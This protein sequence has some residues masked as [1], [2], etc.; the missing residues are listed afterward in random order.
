MGEFIEGT[1]FDDALVGGEGDDTL[2]G[3]QGY[4]TLEGLGGND[5]LWGGDDDDVLLGG[6]GADTLDSSLGEDLSE[7][8]AGDDYLIAGFGR[9]TLTGGEGNDLFWVLSTQEG[10]RYGVVTEIVT[11]TDLEAGEAVSVG[12]T[13]RTSRTPEGFPVLVF[14]GTDDFSSQGGEVR[15]EVSDGV[16]VLEADWDGDGAANVRVDFLGEFDLRQR[17]PAAGSVL[18]E[19][20]QAYRIEE[21][22]GVRAGGTGGGDAIEGTDGNDTLIGAAGDDELTGGEG[23][24]LIAGGFG[25]DTL[26]GGAGQDYLIAG[27]GRDVVRGGEDRDTLA[28]D[29]LDVL[30]A[31][32][33]TVTDVAVNLDAEALLT[34]EDVEALIISRRQAGGHEDRLDASAATI[35]VGLY[36]GEGNDTLIGGSGADTIEGDGGVDVM[37]GG[38]GADVFDFDDLFEIGMLDDALEPVADVIVDFEPAD[39]LDL[40]GLNG[41]GSIQFIGAGAFTAESQLRYFHE[42]GRTIVE[43]NEFGSL[44][45]IVLGSGEFDL[46]ETSDGSFVFRIASDAASSA[47]ADALVGS[48][49]ADEMDGLEGDDTVLGLGG[50]DLMVGG[51]GSDVLRGGVGDD[52]IYGDGIA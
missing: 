46:T 1:R 52:V 3:R 11:V 35:D 29:D 16:T 33:V 22:G 42:A 49:G 31:I 47:I 45:Q 12:P 2:Y 10:A 25:N 37:T 26:S 41:F 7:G 34:M 14:V 9:D 21:D 38:L 19:I 43:T 23:A 5:Y 44:Q 15:Y 28:L 24:D 51:E 4:D 18:L 36:G 50:D 8:G 20:D 17:H 13:G 48:N 32:D 30:G 39:T 6:A 40:A 27:A